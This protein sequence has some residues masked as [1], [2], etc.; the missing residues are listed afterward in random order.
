M[1]LFGQL[2][3]KPALELLSQHFEDT[4]GNLDEPHREPMMRLAVQHFGRKLNLAGANR[5]R[6]E[7]D[8]SDRRLGDGFDE[9]TRPR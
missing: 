7:D 5:H 1:C 9:S 2:L 6:D 8:L 3:G 4:L